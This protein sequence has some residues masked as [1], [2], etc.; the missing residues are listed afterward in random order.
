M[1]TFTFSSSFTSKHYSPSEPIEKPS[2]TSIS[3]EL[4]QRCLPTSYNHLT[5]RTLQYYCFSKLCRRLVNT[6]QVSLPLNSFQHCIDGV[7]NRTISIVASQ[8]LWFCNVV[9][10]QAVQQSVMQKFWNQCRFL[11]NALHL[12]QSHK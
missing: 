6:A 8:V 12:V 5:V 3:I 10:I 7:R 4:A 1:L 2:I 11:Y 9:T